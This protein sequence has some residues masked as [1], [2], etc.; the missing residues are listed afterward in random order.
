MNKQ[1]FFFFVRIIAPLLCALLPLQAMAANTSP[2]L[3]GYGELKKTGYDLFPLWTGM[4]KRHGHETPQEKKCPD[5][6]CPSIDDWLKFLQSLND[7]SLPTKINAVNAYANRHRYVLDIDNYGVPDYWATARQ[8]LV[9]DGDCEDYAITKYIS[10][11][12][13]GFD[14]DTMR[15]VVVQDTNLRIPHAVLAVYTGNDILILD[16]Q[17]KDVTSHRTIAHYVPVYSINESN[18]WMHLP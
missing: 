14:P 17:T 3:F 13:L 6:D 18:W 12:Q 16:N 11:R 9:R 4:F 2:H 10:L 15:I 5:A 7:K 8:F 1:F